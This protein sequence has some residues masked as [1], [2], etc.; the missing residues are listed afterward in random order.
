MGGSLDPGHRTAAGVSSSLVV[1]HFGT[2][3]RLREAVDARVTEAFAQLIGQFTDTDLQDGQFTSI[4]AAFQDQVGPDSAVLAYMRRLLIDGG[5]AANALFDALYAATEAMMAALESAGVVRPTADAPARAAFLLIN[6]LAVVLFR[7]EV[8]R[9][10]GVDP[11]SRAG[12]RRWGSTVMEIY[13]DGAFDVP[14]E[15]DGTKT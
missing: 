5:P 15:T 6:D 11:F 12:L 7:D 8:A 13:R 4:A 2:K 1:H 9:V 10:L 14:D 3:A